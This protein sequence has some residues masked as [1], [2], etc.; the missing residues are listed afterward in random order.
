[1]P[2]HQPVLL[3]LKFDKFADLPSE[4]DE[5]VES[6]IQI[7]CNGKS[8]YL[9]LYPG[10]DSQSGEGLTSLYLKYDGVKSDFPFDF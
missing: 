9:I 1:M 10:G 4:V 2:T 5:D 3:R 8:W 6:E 7:D